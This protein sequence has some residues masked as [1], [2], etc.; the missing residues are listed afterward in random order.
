[1]PAPAPIARSSSTTVRRA[2][3]CTSSSTA[4]RRRTLAASSQARSARTAARSRPA[5]PTRPSSCGMSS[6][7]DAARGSTDAGRTK[8]VVQCVAKLICHADRLDPGALPHRRQP[9]STSRSATRMRATRSSACPR[10]ATSTSSTR[11]PAASPPRSST[12]VQTLMPALLTRRRATSAASRPSRATRAA[13]RSCPDPT[14]AA[15]APGPVP[16]SPRP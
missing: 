1:M 7:C 5:R 6:A 16:A 12:S 9:T 13:R 8:K 14:T 15:S 2:T 4:A 11:E 10:P 3:S